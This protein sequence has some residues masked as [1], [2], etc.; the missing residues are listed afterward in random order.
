MAP[1]VLS[2]SGLEV[3][4]NDCAPSSGKLADIVCETARTCGRPV[5]KGKSYKLPED[6]PVKIEA[7]KLEK[8]RRGNPES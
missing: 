7:R 6:Y 3:F 8:L 4:D 2:D 1:T 5:R